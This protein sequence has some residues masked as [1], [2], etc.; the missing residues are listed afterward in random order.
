MDGLQLN[1]ETVA[2]NT[3]DQMGNLSDRITALELHIA[4][5]ATETPPPR[6]PQDC[7]LSSSHSVKFSRVVQ[8]MDERSDAEVQETH[9]FPL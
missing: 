1:M 3:W 5:S 2:V 4:S 6:L 7:S 9:K 8:P